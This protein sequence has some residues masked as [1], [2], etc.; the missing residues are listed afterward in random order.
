MRDSGRA[1]EFD[2]PAALTSAALFL[3]NFN[4]IN[5]GVIFN[6]DK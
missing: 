4:G 2:L 6:G 1:R 3:D 5:A